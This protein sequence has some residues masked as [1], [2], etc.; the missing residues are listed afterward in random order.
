MNLQ[1]H[2]L[3]RIAAAALICLLAASAYVLNRSDRHS[4]QVTQAAAESLGRQLEL[5]LLR[6]DAGFGEPRR[7]P[8]FT[9]WKQTAAVPGICIRFETAG[10]A[11]IHSLCSGA[12]LSRPGWPEGFETFYR[13]LFNPGLEIVRPVTFN[14]RVYGT[15]AVASSAEMDMAQAWD[16]IRNL[17]GLSA[18]TV[19]AVCALAYLSVSRALRPAGLIVAGLKTL[20]NGNLAYRLPPFELREWGQTAAAI[21]QLAAVQ[22]QLLE[23][24]QKLAVKLINLQE[25]ERRYLVREL[26]DE[27]GQCLAAINAVA[28]SI[29]HTAEQQCPALVEEAWHIARISTHLMDTV[30]GLLT[31]LRPA[32][33]DELGLAASLNSLVAGWN[34][35]SAGKTRYALSIAGDSGLLPEPLAIA[36]FRIAQECLT[37]TARHAAARNVEVRLV[38]AENRVTL[39][40]EDD[41]VA[42]KLPLPEG[43]GIGLLGI[44]ERI[45]ALHGRLALSL[46]R[47]HGLIVEAE[48]PISPAE[49]VETCPLPQ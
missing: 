31:R 22:Q 25:E 48:L 40:V 16:N 46:A 26:H 36:L 43:P 9:L 27:F 49:E 18:M 2:L 15:L 6:I 19:L 39:T 42:D 3:F 21:N 4:R 28:A 35:R 41:G 44:R 34:M 10:T 37:N 30:R 23:E 12:K 24:R 1:L 20:E 17:L 11:D 8:D 38:I 14:R 45:S 32:E 47:P 29:A 13:R 7:F 5:Q 33:L